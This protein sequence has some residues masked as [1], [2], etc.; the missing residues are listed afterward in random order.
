MP[1]PI[2]T[3]D[4]CGG[5]ESDEVS[6]DILKNAISDD[7][8]SL[9]RYLA[10]LHATGDGKLLSPIR[11]G[12]LCRSPRTVVKRLPVGFVWVINQTEESR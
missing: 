3:I 9:H 10:Y 12:N 11:V 7:L 2:T 1:P 4:A 8:V 6:A 5:R